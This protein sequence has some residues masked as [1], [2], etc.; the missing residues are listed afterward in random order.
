MNRRFSVELC[1]D[2]DYDDMVVYI[3]CDEIPLA[4]LNCEKGVDHMELEMNC[5]PKNVHSI[6]FPLNDFLE[7]LSFAKLTLSTSQKND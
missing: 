4:I 2:L 6:K 5:L 3:S 1:S 7:V